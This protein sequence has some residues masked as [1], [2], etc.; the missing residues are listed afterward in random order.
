MLQIASG[1]T[2]TGDYGAATCTGR[3]LQLHRAAMESMVHSASKG[4]RMSFKLSVTVLQVRVR[5]AGERR[6]RSCADAP[7][8]AAEKSAMAFIQ[9]SAA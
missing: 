2:A 5:G 6:H 7:T 8:V 3:W 1:A 9:A 4:Q